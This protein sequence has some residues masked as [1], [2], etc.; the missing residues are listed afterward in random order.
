MGTISI[1]RLCVV[2]AVVG[3]GAMLA[4]ELGEKTKRD[5]PVREIGPRAV[6]DAG[7]AGAVNGLG[8]R[9]YGRL[10]K[11]DGRRNLFISPASV[12]MAL[13]MTMN[14]AKGRTRDEMATALGVEKMSAN[15]V[16][17][18]N[19]QLLALLRNPDPKVELSVA[20]SL[21]GRRGVTFAQAFHEANK[22]GYDAEIRSIDFRAATSADE[23]NH[24]VGEKTKGKIAKLVEHDS[25]REA[26]LVLINAIYFKGTWTMPFDRR[27]THDEQFTLIDGSHATVPMMQHTA[28]YAYLETD[29]FQAVALPYGDRRVE[30]LVI[31]PAED[32]AL[33][34]FTKHLTRESWDE[35][36][37]QMAS[38]RGTVMLPRFRADY[39]TSLK[40]AL[41]ALGMPLAFSDAADLTGIVTPDALAR[42]GG[43]PFISD[44][45]HKTALDVNEEGTTAAAATGVVVGVTSM[46]MDKPFELKV[47]RP[48]FFAIRDV[49]SGVILF[50]GTITN[51]K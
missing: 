43:R 14:G 10:A 3:G 51:P 33:P 6:V 1:A 24:W 5:A 45:V 15:A 18:A 25:I 16:N 4:G 39:G 29:R 44:V 9:L 20:N 21:W 47:D 40:A 37:L 32:A 49:P 17:A 46:P 26:L 7:L 42:L 27:A 13:A 36:M 28:K 38:R 19:A 48:F 12:E 31:L 2:L 23:I 22:T 41:S 30:A 50:M 8:F 11:S 35:W 34:D